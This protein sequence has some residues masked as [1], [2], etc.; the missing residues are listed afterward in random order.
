[1]RKLFY[2][3]LTL[4]V[5][6]C[7][8]VALMLLAP[9]PPR[10]ADAQGISSA[11]LWGCNQSAQY[12]GGAATTVLVAS[13][14]NSGTYVCGFVF[15][16]TAAGSAGLIQGATG[17]TC[18]TPTAVTPVFGVGGAGSPGVTDHLEVYTGLPPV[19]TGNDLCLVT[20]GGAT[21]VIV[22]YTRIR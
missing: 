22:Y 18:P 8:A 13:A 11:L 20:T 16:G 14:P 10:P 17:G 12:S 7:G 5:A 1:M 9:P 15:A 21:Q 19:L 2:R 6:V 4:L 3:P